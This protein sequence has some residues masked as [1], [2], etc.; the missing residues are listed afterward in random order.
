MADR[1][2]FYCQHVL[3]MG[4]LVRDAEIVSELPLGSQVLVKL[5][6]FHPEPGPADTGASS[7]TG[8][9]PNRISVLHRHVFGQSDA[10][11]RIRESKVFPA[12]SFGDDAGGCVSPRW[13]AM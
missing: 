10:T 4:H 2:A 6:S 3:G 9:C 11:Q 12:L 13:G 8:Q 7:S 5:S 1:V